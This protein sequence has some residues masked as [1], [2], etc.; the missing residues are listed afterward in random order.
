MAPRNQYDYIPSDV[1]PS[2]VGHRF[3][4]TEATSRY[5]FT[6]TGTLAATWS[7][8]T[9]W[10]TRL[11]CPHIHRSSGQPPHPSP[12]SV[13]ILAAIH[14]TIKYLRES[15]LQGP[16]EAKIEDAPKL[17]ESPKAEALEAEKP[18]PAR[19]WPNG[20]YREF[21]EDGCYVGPYFW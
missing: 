20:E 6:L 16:S 9:V 13:S 18:R 4:E 11:R 19:V 3:T 17:P 1:L 21:S 5:P 2:N 12:H 10:A 8:A 15:A 14:N 7:R